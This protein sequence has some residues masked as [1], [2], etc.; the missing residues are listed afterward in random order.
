MELLSRDVIPIWLSLPRAEIGYIKFLFESYEGVAVV[1]T[2]DPQAALLVVLAVPDF[3]D[4]VRR[5][6]A[7]LADEIDCRVVDP[8]PGVLDLLGPDR[9]DEE[10]PR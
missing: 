3:L 6:V 8:P 2:W 4:D 10:T 7:A 9:A 5:V 1:R